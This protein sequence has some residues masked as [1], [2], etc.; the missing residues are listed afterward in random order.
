MPDL[1]E[2]VVQHQL[3]LVLVL[4]TCLAEYPVG[5]YVQV[6]KRAMPVV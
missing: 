4:V 3:K 2:G 6:V 5:M 1:L